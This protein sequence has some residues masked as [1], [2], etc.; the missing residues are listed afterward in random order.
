MNETDVLVLGA[1]PAGFAAALC[2]AQRGY[3]V[4]ILDAA[5][6]P[7]RKICGE[8]LNPQAVGWLSE[9]HLMEGILD[10]DPFPVYGMKV[11]DHDGNEFTGHYLPRDVSRGYAIL[12]ERLDHYLVSHARTSG[13]EVLEGHRVE[14]LLMSGGRIT[15]VAGVD[16]RG[17]RFVRGARFFVGAD[18]RNNLIGRTFGWVK[19]LRRL[20]KYVF[21]SYFEPLPQ[22]DHFGEIHL[23]QNGYIGVA[24]ITS[25]L[26]NVALVIDE[27]AYPSASESVQE[28]LMNQI[29]RSSLKHRFTGLSP[30][31]TVISA[32]PLAFRTIRTSGSCALLIGDACG[33]ID[34]FTGEGINHS[35]IG[36]EIAANVIDQA[37]RTCSFDDA[38]LRRYDEERKRILGKKYRIAKMLQM[39]V[40][41]V[42]LGRALI[43]RF[44][45]DTRAADKMVS[46]VGGSLPESE[47]WNSGFLLRLLRGV[48]ADGNGGG[49]ET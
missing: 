44:A 27:A 25:S 48:L 11:V 49:I 10:L 19:G 36:A 18:G 37:F 31:S 3:S 46:V 47:I 24:P 34:P 2:L 43:R 32:G 13:V 39:L 6:F 9:H 23:V 12:R 20:R 21:L 42:A 26:A 8:F 7:R 14:R 17:E 15:G 22:L 5:F 29:N 41:H 35:F 45:V 16:S 33:F 30:V 40:P 4:E 38:F 1:G 28:F